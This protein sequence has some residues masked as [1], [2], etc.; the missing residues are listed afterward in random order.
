M[1]TRP[2]KYARVGVN[3]FLAPATPCAWIAATCC[4][5]FARTT[6]LMIE[7]S[8]NC[9]MTVRLRALIASAMNEA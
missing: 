2:I 6:P 5:A 4:W 1:G 8:N 3:R 9:W 7:A